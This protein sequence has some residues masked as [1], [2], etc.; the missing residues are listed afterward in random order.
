MLSATAKAGGFHIQGHHP[1]YGRR[2]MAADEDQPL[3]A[4]CV[5]DTEE[6]W[7]T[8]YYPHHVASM[9]RS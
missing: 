9:A 6:D 7:L 1:M 2:A 3:N 4:A 5:D 8:P